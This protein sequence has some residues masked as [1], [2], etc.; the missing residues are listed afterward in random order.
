MVRDSITGQRYRTI[1]SDGA[2]LSFVVGVDTAFVGES[3][4]LPASLGLTLTDRRDRARAGVHWQRK[5]THGFFGVT[6]LGRE[7]TTQSDEQVVGS[8]RLGLKF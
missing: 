6:Y 3:M 2:G 7:F 4:Y 5:N 1:L 8:I